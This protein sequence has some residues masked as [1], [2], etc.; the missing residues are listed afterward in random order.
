M[1]F[2]NKKKS[3]FFCFIQWP[4]CITI[5]DGAKHLFIHF[6]CFLKKV[7]LHSDVL[8][9]MF[10]KCHFAIEL[11]FF[12][13]KISVSVL[14]IWSSIMDLVQKWNPNW[15]RIGQS[16]I[17]ESLFIRKKNIHFKSKL[18]LWLLIFS[19]SENEIERFRCWMIIFFDWS[20]LMLIIE[21]WFWMFIIITHMTHLIAK[22][23]FFFS[24]S[25]LSNKSG[26]KMKKVSHLDNKS[27]D[28]SMIITL[29][30]TSAKQTNTYDDDYD[31]DGH[32]HHHTEWKKGFKFFPKHSN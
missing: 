29:S 26:L 21:N 31:Y 22:T 13:C 4:N 1:N 23:L 7:L 2:D 32:D 18:N 3:I 20:W 25:L 8:C 15:L 6:S 9:L 16:S 12:F 27:W 28:F 17:I 30:M 11:D 10:L 19:M 5:N 24:S 14:D